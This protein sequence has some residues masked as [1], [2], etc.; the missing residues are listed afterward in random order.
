VLCCR[1][2]NNARW[3]EVNDMAELILKIDGG[4]VEWIIEKIVYFTIGVLIGL[5]FF[6]RW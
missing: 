5:I 2:E 6:C 3:Q 1:K 4:S